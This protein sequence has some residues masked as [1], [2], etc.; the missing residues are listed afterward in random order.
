LKSEEAKITIQKAKNRK[1][2]CG[3]R[4]KNRGASSR[5]LNHLSLHF[6]QQE[7]MKKNAERSGSIR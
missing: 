2:A 6:M 5:L 3:K 7:M 1:D 4:Y